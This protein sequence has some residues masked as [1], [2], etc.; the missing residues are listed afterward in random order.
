[1]TILRDLAE[2][3]AV[4]L[5]LELM[6]ILL[7]MLAVFGGLAFGMRRINKNSGAGF[8]KV[9]GWVDT[10]QK[11]VHK[12]TDYVALPFVLVGRAVSTVDGTLHGIRQQVRR[13]QS[14]KEGVEMAN[15]AAKPRPPEQEPNILV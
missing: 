4:L 14:R 1:M 6:V 2:A 8:A 11:Y 9:N 13:N 15:E 7:V 10:G 12:G 5:L 3:A